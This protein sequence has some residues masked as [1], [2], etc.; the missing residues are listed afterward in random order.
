M[1]PIQKFNRQLA[2]AKLLSPQQ[3]VVVAVST[4]VDS[5]VLLH[6]LQRLPAAERPRVVVAHVNHHL[7]EQ[8]QMEADYLRQY[9]QQQNL[10]LVMA[11]W[12]PAAHPKSGIEA[13]GR[14]FRYHV[15]AK[16]MRENRA[17]AVLTAHHANDQVETYLMKLARGGD[18]SQLTGIAT[19][20]PFATGRLIRP[21]LTWSKDQ[22][23]NYAAEQHVVYFEDVT[24]QDVALT[25]NRIRHRV[26]PELMTVN[27]QLLKHVADYQQQL[28][29]LLTAK[30]QMV[31]VLLSQVVTVTGALVVDQW[32]ALPSQWQLAVF[33][34]WLE[35]QTQQLFTESK[36]QPLVS[37]GQRTRPATSRLTV[38]AAWEL[39]RNAGIIEALPIK[40]RG[41]K[42]MPRE[43]IMVD[44][45]Q[46]QKITAT[47][48]VGIFTRVPNVVSQP[49]WLTEADWPLVWRPWQAGDRIVLKGGG[50][51]LVRRLLID[52][53][54]P[55]ERREQVQVLVNAQGN[56]LWVVGHKF[57]YRTT[58]TQTVFLALKH[59]S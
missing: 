23:R 8:S 21:L 9:C 52:R 26:V 54:V 57:S 38:N 59:E 25:R 56:V 12:L 13:A 18:I 20:R 51:Q 32:G 15:F 42:L 29:T 44:L 1:T 24:N 49:F 40:K 31:T 2:A 50:H 58:G 35:Q 37:W 11:D 22:L 19:S 27:P 34:T 14:Q 6:L 7:R 41:K 55:A 39:Y 43:K 47:Q 16:V 48:T 53:K 45:N 10:K 4:G 17:T 3:T 46:W 33:A 36:L 30:K 28:T 5:M